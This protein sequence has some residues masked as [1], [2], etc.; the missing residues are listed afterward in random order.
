MDPGQNIGFSTDSHHP[1]CFTKS[2]Y[3]E[4][5]LRPEQQTNHQVEMSSQN[6]QGKIQHLIK[7]L[8]YW[9]I[10]KVILVVELDRSNHF[11]LRGKRKGTEINIR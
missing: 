11:Q 8:L 2:T 1:N 7:M 10:G 5:F 6:F 9:K 3:S 4:E